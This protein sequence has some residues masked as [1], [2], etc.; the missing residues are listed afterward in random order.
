MRIEDRN[1]GIRLQQTSKVVFRKSPKYARPDSPEDE[2]S[3]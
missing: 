1:M 3:R 2:V